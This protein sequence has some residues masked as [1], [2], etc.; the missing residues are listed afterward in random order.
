MIV[1]DTGVR[2]RGAKAMRS[3]RKTRQ[4]GASVVE[5]A[6]LM[7]ILFVVLFGIFEFGMALWYQQELTSA[8]RE[9]AR[10]GVTLT[11]RT[12]TSAAITKYATDYLDGIGL[13][14]SSRTVTC[15]NNPTSS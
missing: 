2:L 5:F 13:K 10:K 11:A 6:L 1:A 3:K 9:G 4:H 12:W 14:D 15:S 7:P 8:V